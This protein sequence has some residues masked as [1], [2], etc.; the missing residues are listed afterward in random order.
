MKQ[1]CSYRP[2]PYVAALHRACTAHVNVHE[3][4]S[5]RA[6]H[7]YFTA[8]L[9]VEQHSLQLFRTRSRDRNPKASVGWKLALLFKN[10]HHFKEKEK[11]NMLYICPSCCKFRACS[12]HE[13][14]G[15]DVQCLSHIQA[16]DFLTLWAQQD[17][18]T[19]LNVR[20]LSAKCPEMSASSVHMGVCLT[21]N[22][23]GVH[24]RTSL[25]ESGSGV[26]RRNSS[27]AIS[28]ADILSRATA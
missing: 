7:P 4:T 3:D 16:Q 20:R 21:D 6:H 9:R 5:T 13:N 22:D 8:Q 23:L 10:D 25:V 19:V 27:R 15:E 28:A 17:L 26:Q 1:M 11:E 18:E 12:R 14:V 24:A 2:E